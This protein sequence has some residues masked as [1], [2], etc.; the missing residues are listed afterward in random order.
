MSWRERLTEIKKDR[1]QERY[2]ETEIQKDKRD[3]YIERWREMEIERN[4]QTERDRDK[5]REQDQE[6][7]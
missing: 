2:G 3:R 1:D 5:L 6:R 7:D 4:I